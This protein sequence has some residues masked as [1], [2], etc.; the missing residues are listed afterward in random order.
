MVSQV[1]VDG[2][3]VPLL[4]AE[5]RQKCHGGKMWWRK[6]APL[7]VTKKQR[8]RAKEEWPRDK[9]YP[10]DPHLQLSASPTNTYQV[11]GPLLNKPLSC[12]HMCGLIHLTKLGPHDP[13]S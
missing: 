13:T 11:L 4:R 7:M 3:L 2:Q 9:L 12:E 8:E 10:S 1:S 6:T 5:V